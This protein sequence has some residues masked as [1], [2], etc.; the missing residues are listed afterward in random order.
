MIK[1]LIRRAVLL[2]KVPTSAGPGGKVSLLLKSFSN[3]SNKDL[4]GN[5]CEPSCRSCD[6]YLEI[7]LKQSVGGSCLVS[8]T[9]NTYHD[10][11]HIVFGENEGFYRGGRNPLIWSFSSWKVCQS[12]AIKHKYIG[13]SYKS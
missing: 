12:K 3:P 10:T 5:C 2:P 11:K 9:T 7:C 1:H 4:N 8:A 6:Y 13:L